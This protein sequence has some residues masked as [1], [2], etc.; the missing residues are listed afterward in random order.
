VTSYA[1]VNGRRTVYLPVTKRA[2]ASTLT[3]VDLVKKSIPKFQSAV[4]DDVKVTFEFDQT[5]VVLRAIKNL[6]EEGALGAVLTGLMVLLFLRSVRSAFIVVIN[7]PIALLAS[8][9]A[10]WVSGQNI[11]LMSLGGLALA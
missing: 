6:V 10:L 9:F 5:P 7:I 11:H 3:V 8:C 4:P 2:D 1:L